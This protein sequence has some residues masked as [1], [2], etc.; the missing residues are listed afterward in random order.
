M[1]EGF[2]TS[3]CFTVDGKLALPYTYFAGRVGSKF[4]TTIRD[5]KKIMGI[6]CNKCNKVFVPPRQTCDVCM[7]DIR[8]NWVDVQ[9][10]GEITNFTVV[11]YDDK[12]L[13]KEASLNF[14]DPD[15]DY[16]SNTATAKRTEGNA[17]SNISVTVPLVLTADEAASMAA[18]MLW[19]AWLGQTEVKF[20]L[21]EP[22]RGIE[23]GRAYGIPA[24]GQI[25]PY[26]L[27]R[28]LRG[29]N[30]L[31]EATAVSDESVTYTASVEGSSGLPPDDDPR[32]FVKLLGHF[33]S[34]LQ[35][36][37]PL[38]SSCRRD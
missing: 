25:V 17:K 37:Q 29:A 6:K 19:D 15:R 20:T 23:V 36:C 22:W 7:E 3:D 26:R 4:L 34:G 18:L 10:T 12:H 30:G 1:K 35:A 2:D 13:P 28:N 32:Q 27:L 8:D 9:N 21:T 16:N 11:R 5:E 24:A 38:S 33:T 14:I 31:I